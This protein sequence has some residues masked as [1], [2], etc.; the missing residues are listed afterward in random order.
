MR[1][2]EIATDPMTGEYADP[3]FFNGLR[4]YVSTMPTQTKQAIAKGDYATMDWAIRQFKVLKTGV[5]SK[6]NGGRTLPSQKGKGNFV[7]SGSPA[8][9]GEGKVYTKAELRKMMAQNP[10]EYAAKSDEI[11]L[12]Y[13]EGRVR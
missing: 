3:E 11:Q 8:R 9:S 1:H 7:E 6:A 5:A 12:A 2:P 10:A 13:Q 4:K